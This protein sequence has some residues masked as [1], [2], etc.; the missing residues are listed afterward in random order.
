MP[1][2]KHR[3]RRLEGKT[4]TY[5]LIMPVAVLDAVK[6]LAAKNRVS[7]ATIVRTAVRQS[8]DSEFLASK[9]RR[10][11]LADTE[12]GFRLGV[13]AAC[14]KVASSARLGMKT[15]IG[16]TIG[17]DIAGRIKKDLLG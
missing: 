7:P 2:S 14:E 8:I 16:I 1:P 4:Q 17:E 12:E 15:A 9:P 6:A 13:E 5:N 11:T 3:P 10:V